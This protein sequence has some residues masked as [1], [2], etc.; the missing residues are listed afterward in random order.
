[1]VSVKEARWWIL[2]VALHLLEEGLEHLQS[3]IF[4][5]FLSLPRI[6]LVQRRSRE[7]FRNLVREHVAVV[8]DQVV[9]FGRVFGTDVLAIVLEH[10]FWNLGVT[11]RNLLDRLAIRSLFDSRVTDPSPI[12][13]LPSINHNRSVV[14]RIDLYPHEGHTHRLRHPHS[15]IVHE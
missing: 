2:H 8:V 14:N 7:K 13:V 12:E 3:W 11:D 15:D 1:M 10:F 5:Q 9:L 4:E 6:F